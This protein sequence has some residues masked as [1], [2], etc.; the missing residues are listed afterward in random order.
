M[1]AGLRA[2]CHTYLAAT[3]S[4]VQPRFPLLCRPP[5]ARTSVLKRRQLWS[6][7]GAAGPRRSVAGPKRFGARRPPAPPPRPAG[8]RWPAAALLGG[9]LAEELDRRRDDLVALAA[10]AALGLPLAVGEA[11]LDRDLA[12]LRQVLVAAV[13]EL[14]ERRHVDEVRAAVAASLDRQAHDGDVR[15]AGGGALLGVAGQ[16]ADESDA[17]HEVFSFSRPPSGGLDL[18]CAADARRP[19]GGEAT[20]PA[21]GSPE[22]SERLA[23]RPPGADSQSAKATGARHQVDGTGGDPGQ[24]PPARQLR[25]QRSS[26]AHRRPDGPL[27]ADAPS[28]GYSRRGTSCFAG[29]H[30]DHRRSPNDGSARTELD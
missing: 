23:R 29:P 3:A 11:A 10:L 17:V 19:Q 12:A 16:A 21:T 5:R 24:Q 25:Y 20:T 2:L 30:R 26:S 1:F 13:G 27:R 7:A 8:A 15:A 9:P 18:A 28:K 14:A 4:R 6:C 22:R